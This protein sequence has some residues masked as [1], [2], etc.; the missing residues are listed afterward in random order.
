MESLIKRRSLHS[1]GLAHCNVIKLFMVQKA[2]RGYLD[3]MKS[4]VIAIA[5]LCVSASPALAETFSQPRAVVELFT[6]QGC[7]SSPDANKA[8]SKMDDVDSEVLTLSYGV[9]YWDYLGWKD[10]TG[11]K[12]SADRQRLYDRAL[13]TGLYTP[14]VVVGGQLHGAKMKT[15]SAVPHTVSAS[16]RLVRRSGELCLEGALPDNTTLALVDYHPGVQT[17][18]VKGGQN[19]GKTVEITNTVTNVR[20]KSWSGEMMCGFYPKA[21]LAV[22]AHDPETSAIIGAARFEP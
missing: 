8:V 13:D 5:A 10:T 9:N 16:L 12:A 14:M 2:E 11:H 1:K 15:M 6:S 19:K 18:E 22:L 7:P 21:G 4:P 20:Y 17:V 3:F